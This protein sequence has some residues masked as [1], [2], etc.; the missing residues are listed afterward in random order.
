MKSKKL[1]LLLSLV[2]A[3]TPVTSFAE[4]LG[5]CSH[6][7]KG[8]D[9]VNNYEVVQNADLAWVRDECTWSTTETTKGNLNVPENVKR[10]FKSLHESGKKV[11]LV[12][13]YGANS[14]YTLSDG[15]QN[16]TITMP[17]SDEAEYMAAWKNYVTTIAEDLG[18]Y[19]DAYEVWNEPDLA[20][21]NSLIPE[22]NVTA[23]DYAA[24]AEA[25]VDL[26]VNTKDLLDVL[27]HEKPVLFG[28]LCRGGASDSTLAFY[29]EMKAVAEEKGKTF[30]EYV[31]DV[32]IH[33]YKTTVSD[34]TEE[35]SNW[36]STFDF[37]GFTGDVWL[38][39]TGLSE[40]AED[41]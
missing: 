2:I 27:Q 7:S 31:D 22:N 16:T 3:L 33:F 40:V 12:L 36:E 21:A 11:L 30:D 35:L 20:Y 4:G 17:T 28:T 38:T 9:E 24:A 8:Y 32:S 18:E 19:V 29:N 1:A 15:N 6:V 14:Y 26:Y 23:A 37:V 39:E 34:A 10:Y 5:V 25:Y 41:D 13:D